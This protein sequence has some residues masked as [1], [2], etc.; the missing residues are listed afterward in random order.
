MSNE[1]V[2]GDNERQS[3]NSTAG[4]PLGRS[5]RQWRLGGPVTGRLEPGDL[6]RVEGARRARLLNRLSP[7]EVRWEL[8]ADDVTNMPVDAARER[9]LDADTP[10]HSHATFVVAEHTIH[11]DRISA[12]QSG[13]TFAFREYRIFVDHILAGAGGLQQCG[14]GAPLSSLPAVALVGESRAVV[15]TENRDGTPVIELSAVDMQAGDRDESVEDPTEPLTVRTGVLTN[16]EYAQLSPE[17]QEIVE[18]QTRELAHQYGEESLRAHREQH[19][20]D[21]SFIYGV[22]DDSS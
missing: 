1:H 15:I 4:C 18:R 21:L 16:G 2:S 20:A 19:R 10:R 13:P 14:L 22:P 17:L 7:V 5:W 9:H 6:M 11:I 3:S 12:R 8:A